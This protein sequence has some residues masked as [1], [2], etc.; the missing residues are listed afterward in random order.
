MRTAF[1]AGE[2]DHLQ[3]HAQIAAEYNRTT[4]NPWGTGSGGVTSHLIASTFGLGTST[5][6]TADAAAISAFYAALPL[7][8]TQSGLVRGGIGVQGEFPNGTWYCDQF[9]HVIKAPASGG[10]DVTLTGQT[11]GGT[12]LTALDRSP[13]GTN[14]W[15]GIS[16]GSFGT[17][18]NMT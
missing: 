13:G 11:A 17:I 15:N 5:D 1:Q 9:G 6:K 16:R 7:L 18:G 12:T 3:I 10:G 4:H 14:K 2:Q 8:F